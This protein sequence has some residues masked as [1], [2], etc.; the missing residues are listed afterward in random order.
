MPFFAVTSITYLRGPKDLYIVL[1]TDSLA[2]L[3]LRQTD[4]TIRTRKKPAYRR[5][6]TLMD[7][8]DICF[9]EYD[10]MEQQEAGGTLTHTWHITGWKETS[11]HWFYF[12]GTMAAE[13]TPCTTAIYGYFYDYFVKPRLLERWSWLGSGPPTFNHLF[14]E[15]WSS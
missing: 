4:K 5:G 10:D 7:D 12:W 14:T 8:L 3:W 15:H 6:G 2:H 9:V 11:Y 13:W 1:V